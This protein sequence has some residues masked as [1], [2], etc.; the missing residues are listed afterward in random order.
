MNIYDTMIY[1]IKAEMNKSGG[2]FELNLSDAEGDQLYKISKSHDMVHIVGNVLIK[3]KI[4]SAKTEIYDKFQKQIMIAMYRYES[5]NYDFSRVAKLFER[6][7]IKYIP[8]KGTVIRKMYPVPWMRTSCDIDILIEEKNFDRAAKCLLDA[9]L[10]KGSESPHDITFITQSGSHIELHYSL[11]EKETAS[12]ADSV[13]RKVWEG[14][15]EHKGYSY[16]CD[17]SDEMFYFYHIA[18]M[19]KHFLYGGCGIKPFV[20]L[21]I[22]DDLNGIDRAKRDELLK[23]GKLLP[24]A[25]SVRRLSKI[26][27]GNG[28]H[29]PITRQ[30]EDYILRGGVYGSSENR[31][32]VQQQKKGG[33]IKYVLSKIFI[34]YDT[35]KFH[36]PILQKHRWLTPIMQVRRW[37]KLIFCGHLKRTAREI[38]YNSSISDTEAEKMQGFLSDIGL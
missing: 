26:W 12:D 31:I 23:R 29:D 3:N 9:G 22:L 37:G 25:E 8:L 36:Y 38:R 21:W 5:L 2:E 13:L 27:F 10:Q 30:M 34:P 15:A 24:F 1:C 18:H 17:M 32:T 19:A 14:S 16:W 20:D 6:E 11:I 7:K 35:I 28:E 4:I 33:R